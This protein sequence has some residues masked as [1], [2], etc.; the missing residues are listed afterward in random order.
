MTT[1]YTFYTLETL[2]QM[3]NMIKE[4]CS[5]EKVSIILLSGDLSSGKTTFV[6]A[7]VALFNAQIAVT[8]PTFSIVHEYPRM[9]ENPSETSAEKISMIYH[10]D[11]YRKSWSELL[12]LGIVEMITK[13]GIHLIEWPSDELVQLLKSYTIKALRIAISFDENDSNKRQYRIEPLWKITNGQPH[14]EVLWQK[15]GFEWY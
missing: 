6:K 1:A 9:H 13:E 11:L 4:R 5:D 14:R 2:S 3:A 10:Y 7:F 15:T 12:G 8:S